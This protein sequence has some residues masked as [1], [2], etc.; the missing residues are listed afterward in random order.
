MKFSYKVRTITKPTPHIVPPGFRGQLYLYQ[1]QALNWIRQKESKDEIVHFLGADQ[2]KRFYIWKLPGVVPGMWLWYDTE[3]GLYTVLGKNHFPSSTRTKR[4]ATR[5]GILT[6]P[7]GSGKTVTFIALCL[8]D[9]FT[10]E[11]YEKFAGSA[12]NMYPTCIAS[13]ATLVVV[14]LSFSQ[15]TRY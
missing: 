13:L 5:G 2:S 10:I 14:G 15:S 11:T 4:I 6:D 8:T 7:P 3:N 1:Q 12:Y 9:S